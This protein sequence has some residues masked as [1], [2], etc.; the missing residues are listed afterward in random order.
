MLEDPDDIMTPI[1]SVKF[2]SNSEYLAAGCNDGKVKLFNLRQKK[3]FQV[4]NSHFGPVSSVDWSSQGNI[5][6]SS[7]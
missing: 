5:L 2:T 6:A 1:N 3:L 4:Y 7:S